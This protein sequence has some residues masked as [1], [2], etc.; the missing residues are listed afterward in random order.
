MEFIK[1]DFE[2][3]LVGLCVNGKPKGLC[4][5]DTEYVQIPVLFGHALE[6][7]ENTISGDKEDGE[8]SLVKRATME[9]YCGIP[10]SET[11]VVHPPKVSKN[12]GSDRRIKSRR[13]IAIKGMRKKGRT[14]KTC[15]LANEHDS[16]NCVKRKKRKLGVARAQTQNV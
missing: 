11:I 7:L 14:C 5:C 10:A 9:T 6:G 8:T 3:W 4:V 15:G 1:G 13:E 2:I 12:K 16:R